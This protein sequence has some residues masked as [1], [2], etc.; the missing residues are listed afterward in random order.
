MHRV[1]L[2]V[3]DDF[4]IMSCAAVAAFDVANLFAN[5]PSTRA[6]SPPDR[7]LKVRLRCPALSP[8]KKKRSLR[9]HRGHAVD[10][11]TDQ[12]GPRRA[13]AFRAQPSNRESAR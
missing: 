5:S 10:E 9:M 13:S 1:G 4:Q 2:V 8:S 7:R 6:G 11:S 12:P 3:A